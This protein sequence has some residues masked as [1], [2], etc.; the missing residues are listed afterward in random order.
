MRA[1]GITMNVVT[2]PQLA[3]V[4]QHAYVAFFARHGVQVVPIPNLVEDL[5]RYVKQTAVE[6]L[7]MTGGNDVGQPRDGILKGSVAPMRDNCERALLNFAMENRLP[8]FGI[9]RGMQFMNCFFG[10]SLVNDI[11]CVTSLSHAGGTHEVVLCDDIATRVLGTTSAVVNSFH[12]HGVTPETMAPTLK[13][14]A[15]SP[16]G[17]VIEAV[18]HPTFPILGIQ[19]HPERSGCAAILSD[20]IVRAFL[21]G[22]INNSSF[23]R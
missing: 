23:S 20:G 15:T 22:E 11:A 7:I 5:G 12:N 17:T 4:L 14:V 19:W 3:D 16:C 13:C 8:V 6:G 18:R 9:C 2:T 1:F 21:N 10:G